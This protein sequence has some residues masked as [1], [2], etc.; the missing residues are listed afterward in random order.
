MAINAKRF[1]KERTRLLK[2]HGRLLYKRN[3][4]NRE[5]RQV[6]TDMDAWDKVLFNEKVK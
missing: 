1:V 2:E 3:E 5:L 4:L 6:K